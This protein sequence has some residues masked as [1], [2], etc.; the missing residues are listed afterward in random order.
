MRAERKTRLVFPSTVWSSPLQVTGS[1]AGCQEVRTG[2]AG[3]SAEGPVSV[4][5][6]S[7][8]G[9]LQEGKRH[10]WSF[11]FPSSRIL[12]RDW[13]WREGVNLC[14]VR[15]CLLPAL[16]SST[17]LLLLHC[18]ARAELPMEQ[19]PHCTAQ[20]QTPPAPKLRRFTF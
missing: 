15:L 16:F 18:S 2:R 5:V 12:Q 3:P 13:K 14:A 4:T 1:I 6:C 17:P 11:L 9:Q 19:L 8:S 20:A 10:K 7:A